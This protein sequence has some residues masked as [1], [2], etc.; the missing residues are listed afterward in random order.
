[1]LILD[2]DHLS[3]LERASA[4]ADVLRSRLT[5]SGKPAAVTIM[6]VEEQLRGRLAQIARTRDSVRLIGRYEHL[7]RTVLEFLGIP[8]L[9][10]TA[11]AAVVYE[12]LR[13]LKLGIGTMDLR[14]ASVALAVGGLLLSRNLRDFALLPQ[15]CVEDWLP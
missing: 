8:I 7:R 5:A 4:G 11:E 10:W 3:A 12:R 9:P 1:M 2:T 13:S 14:I 15:L 6:T